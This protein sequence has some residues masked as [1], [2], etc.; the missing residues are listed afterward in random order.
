[1]SRSVFIQ[2]II[3][4]AKIKKRN[5]V[6]PE[7]S[8]ERVLEAAN[9]INQEGIASITILGSNPP[10]TAAFSSKGWSLEGI[11]VINPE[12]SDKLQEYADAFF[13]LRQAKGITP[14]QALEAVKQVNY[15]GM[16]MMHAGDADGL[17]SGA[18]HSTADTVRPALQI[19][20][21]MK[22]GATVSS[23]F[24]M[25]VSDKT[26]IFSDCALVENP[27]AE[28]LADIAV[29]SAVSALAYDIPPKVALLSYSTYG[30]GKSEM[31]EKVS[32][33]VELAKKKVAE[34]YP[35][36][37]IV[38]DGELQADAAIVPGVALSKAPDSP[39]GGEARVLIFPDLNAANIGY[40]L[41]Q[42][43]AGA[44][45]YGPILQGLNKPVND[46][47]RGCYVEDIVGTV[48]LTALQ[49]NH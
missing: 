8:D 21:S 43:F 34:Q 20:K 3:D 5:I 33:A 49:A 36:L 11:T 40:K 14:E 23:F 38:I 9:I 22:K 41:V 44:G 32:T 30:S 17:V 13:A 35:D 19:I 16:M 2:Q 45:A 4:A 1:M 47:S 18:A 39:L 37:G 6:L 12:N 29:D 10:I 27:T 26:F 28:Q 25:D 7:G 24:I 42:R 48:A 46:L 15:F 31:V